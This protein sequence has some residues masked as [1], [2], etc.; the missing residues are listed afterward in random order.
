MVAR[1]D[2]NVDAPRG[3]LLDPEQGVAAIRARATQIAAAWP[4]W[5]PNAQ[6]AAESLAPD[7]MSARQPMQTATDKP[8]TPRRHV[9]SVLF[10]IR[11]RLFP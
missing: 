2:V 11:C 9:V 3:V 10:S 5:R 1:I 6:V 8:V 4:A 7:A